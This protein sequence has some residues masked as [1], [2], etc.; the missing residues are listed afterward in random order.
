[1]PPPGAGSGSGAGEPARL[2]PFSSA[3]F[4]TS[5]KAH[6]AALPFKA[7]KRTEFYERWLRTPAFG[8]WLARQEE[9]VSGVLAKN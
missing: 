3:D 6:G 9:L 7:G 1:M 2:R 4:I 5:L 8:V